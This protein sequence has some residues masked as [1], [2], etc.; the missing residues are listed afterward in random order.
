LDLDDRITVILGAND[1][2]KTNLLNA[3]LHLNPNYGLTEADL[4][5]DCMGRENEFPVVRFDLALTA[6]ERKQL[7]SHLTE[8]AHLDAFTQLRRQFTDELDALAASQEQP[9]AGAPPANGDGTNGEAAPSDGNALDK[10]ARL[11]EAKQRL[12]IVYME[13]LKFAARLAGLDEPDFAARAE[14]A[15][16][17]ARN[18][19]VKAKRAKTKATAA[20]TAAAQAAAGSA[21][22]LKADS[23]ARSVET[24][25]DE[26]A[27]EAERL[28]DEAVLVRLAADADAVAREGKH[29]FA[30]DARVPSPKIP[31]EQLPELVTL[32][33]TGVGG[34]LH[35][36]DAGLLDGAAL[37]DFMTEHLPRVELFKPVESIPDR[38]TRESIHADDN[39]FMRGIF[40]YAG[41]EPEEWDGLFEQNDVTTM[42]L[43]K[44]TDRLNE[45]LRTAWSQGKNLRFR[46]DHNV[47]VIDLQVKDPA[48]EKTFVRASR[49][50]SGFTHFFAL[51]TM[52]YAR[53][54]ASTAS[55]FLW[56]FDEPG[57]YLHPE[58][59]HDL[60]QVLET[61]AQ[62]N[63]IV[64]VTHSIFLTNKNYPTRHRLLTKTARGTEIDQKPYAGQWRAAIDA[65]GLGFPG[66]FLFASRVLLVEGDSDPILLYTDLQKLIEIRELNID[67]N[68]LSIMATGNSKH[69]DALIRIL[70]EGGLVPKIALLLDGD[71]GG[72]DRYKSVRKLIESKGIL[73]HQLDQKTTVEDHLIAPVLFRDATIRHL[74]TIDAAK[75]PR[76]KLESSFEQVQA[77]GSGLAKW[78][79]EEGGRAIESEEEP[80]AVGI[81][82]EYAVLL[83]D[84]TLDGSQKAT[85]KRGVKLARK[86]AEML[87]LPNQTVQQDR[88]VESA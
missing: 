19:Q 83:R 79:R 20:R 55:S 80:S 59:Q 77:S 2:G 87:D 10:A 47:N 86:I 34:T 75:D 44:A 43:E 18:A 13:E 3:L 54:R 67:I 48:V 60:L 52:L 61:L 53:E 69:A 23:E 57:V 56:L 62:A 88:V 73:C 22:Q 81:A 15:E 33:R 85:R 58:G 46:L 35:L 40:R 9:A 29:P 39:D 32:G 51:K 4:N 68:G 72:S 21:E 24:E 5:F 63:Q 65:L 74:E 78:A 36:V 16:I 76:S 28:S 49:R 12:G 41:L 31:L 11:E 37:M 71:Q 84:A 70:S 6:D 64:Y 82:R 25:A 17:A 42:R 50:S 1:H 45:M 66:T 14:A 8:H 7:R 26:T 30:K 38:A 27:N